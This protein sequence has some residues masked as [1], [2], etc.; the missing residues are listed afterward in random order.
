MHGCVGAM[1]HGCSGDAWMHVMREF[2]STVQDVTQELAYQYNLVDT[3]SDK[4][5]SIAFL[6]IPSDAGE[7]MNRCLLASNVLKSMA[8]P[9]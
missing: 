2:E 3:Y 8:T 1:L 9:G 6:F 5:A 7:T 4:C